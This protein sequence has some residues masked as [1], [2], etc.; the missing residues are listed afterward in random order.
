[1]SQT[2][3]GRLVTV[4]GMKASDGRTKTTKATAM[5]LPA[6]P[7]EAAVACT[8]KVNNAHCILTCI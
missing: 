2:R 4:F 8:R 6:A 1:V 3:A 5:M 7:L